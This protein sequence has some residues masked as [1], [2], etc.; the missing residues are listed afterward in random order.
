MFK[1]WFN[2]RRAELRRNFDVATT[3]RIADGNELPV[4]IVSLSARGFRLKGCEPA[5]EGAQ[6]SIILP[7]YGQVLGRVVWVAGNECGGIL[8]KPIPIAE[9]ELTETAA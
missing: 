7:G 3:A 8:E 9:I 2:R 5:R 1:R 4:R 6:L